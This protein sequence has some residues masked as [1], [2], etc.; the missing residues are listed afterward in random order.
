MSERVQ[1]SQVT[2]FMIDPIHDHVTWST[3]R[4]LDGQRVSGQRL[5]VERSIGQEDHLVI[6]F[7]DTRVEATRLSVL[8]RS[9][10]R[11]NDVVDKSS[12]S[13]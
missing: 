5:V 1:R 13:D 12:V 4:C 9:L 10:S 3:D 6:A 2:Q 7:V 8:F 11:L